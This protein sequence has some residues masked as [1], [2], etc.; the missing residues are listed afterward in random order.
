[1]LHNLETLDVRR[2]TVHE[3]P[4]EINKLRKL[5]HLLAYDKSK[6]VGYGIE[7]K[8][9]IGD[10]TSLQTLRE[11]E[12]DHGGVELITELERVTQLR[13]LGLTNVK[14]EYTSAM[15]SSINEMQQLEKLYIAAIDKHE[16]INLQFD[17]SLPKLRKLCLIGKLEGFSYLVRR[18]QNL[19]K[20][21][22]S[23][24]FHVNS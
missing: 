8:D 23:H 15:C 18:L 21:S 11:V 22:L 24:T 5:R 12:A 16:V 6:A 14:Q 1:M 3:M 19:V 4:R 10:I 2:T 7:M 13:M 9:G 20:L 17:V